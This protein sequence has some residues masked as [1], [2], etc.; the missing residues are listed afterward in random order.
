MTA[1]WRGFDRVLDAL[2]LLAAC[3]V[4]LVFLAIVYDVT[5]RTLRV[6]QI[7]WVVGVTEYALL[8]FTA[9]G[10]PWLL[11][12]RGHVSM[13]AFRAVL[14]GPLNA[15]MEKL[16]LVLCLSACTVVAVAAWPVVI[17]NVGVMDIRSNF[18]TRELLYIP[19]V[20]AFVLCAVQFARFLLT[21]RS[22][23]KGISADQEGL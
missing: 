21:G 11:R 15:A 9:L 14:P 17:Q 5:T 12:E 8:W 22:L 16:V 18:L 20:L 7:S 19:V 10:A 13:E 2:A 3:I 4:P 6:G 23:Y 1:F